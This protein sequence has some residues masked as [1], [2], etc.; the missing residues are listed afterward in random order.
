LVGTVLFLCR[1]G[2]VERQG[3]ALP[4]LTTL[5]ALAYFLFH[6]LHGQVDANWLIPLWPALTLVAAWAVF[7][8]ERYRP[9]LALA[10]MVVQMLL[11][12]GLIGFVYTQA[13]YEPFALG[14]LDRTNETRGWP[15]LEATI[16]GL[17]EANG[18]RWIATQGNYGI[19]GEVAAY[20]LFAHSPLPVRQIDEPLRW[21]FLPASDP[22]AT[23][24]PALF[25][26]VDADPSQPQPPSKWFGTTRLVGR[27]RRESRSGPL[28]TWSAFVVGDPTPLFYSGLKR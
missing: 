11:G 8:R 5:P 4:V 3:P 9:R 18:A 15:A 17:A 20:T 24:W 25:V 7:R 22:D 10:A 19:T 14:A 16:L 2:A 21:D 23:G 27:F 6:T 12:I 28:E 1:P 13:L 26:G